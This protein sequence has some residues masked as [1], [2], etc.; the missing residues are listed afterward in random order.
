[1]FSQYVKDFLEAAVSIF[2]MVNV[3]GN[4]PVFVGLTDDVDTKERRE[5]FRL[6]GLTAFV[7]ICLMAVAGNFLL[8]YVFHIRMP[9]FMLGGGL[10]LIVVGI[11]SILSRP[12]SRSSAPSAPE[13]AAGDI[14]HVSLAVTPIASPLLVGP[15]SIAT[16]MLVASEHGILFAL[17]ACLVTFALVL[18]IL[19]YAHVIYRLMGRV[20]ALA[21]GRIMQIF[22]V[23]IGANFVLQALKDTFPCLGN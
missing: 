1:M 13:A 21:I 16:V 7:L 8:Q 23:A 2:A 20:G 11:R 3:M 5:L 6:A 9:A 19:N 15:G 14:D 12:K 10:I 18:L 17:G 4:L 22:I